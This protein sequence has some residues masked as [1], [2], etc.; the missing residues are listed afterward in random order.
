MTRVDQPE[1]ARAISEARCRRRFQWQADASGPGTAVDPMALDPLSP[2]PS[3]P[4]PRAL[5]PLSPITTSQE[6][7]HA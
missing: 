1:P 6:P 2:L 4:D 3:A 7:S 5:S